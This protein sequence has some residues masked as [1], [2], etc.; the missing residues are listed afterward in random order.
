[1][2]TERCP[3]RDTS[4]RRIPH[5]YNCIFIFHLRFHTSSYSIVTV[6]TAGIGNIFS[7]VMSL[8]HH[9]GLKRFH[10]FRRLRTMGVLGMNPGPLRGENKTPCDWPLGVFITS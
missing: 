6:M 5:A 1:M 9:K 7:I 10:D 2:E 8:S 3:S 4:L